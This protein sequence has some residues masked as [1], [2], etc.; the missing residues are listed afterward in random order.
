MSYLQFRGTCECGR[1]FDFVADASGEQAASFPGL[2]M[3]CECGKI[4]WVR[5]G[6]SDDRGSPVYAGPSWL[7]RSATVDCWFPEHHAPGGEPA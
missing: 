3:R 5:G 7:V 6:T 4:T 1:E 2:R